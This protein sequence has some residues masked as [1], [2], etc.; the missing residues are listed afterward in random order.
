MGG[1]C[2]ARQ[3]I[4]LILARPLLQNIGRRAMVEPTIDLAPTPDAAA[5]H[6]ADRRLAERKAEA[7]VA[8]FAH[9]LVARKM[10]ARVQGQVRPFFQQQRLK[11]RLGAQGGGDGSSRP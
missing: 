4:D 7:P 11:A 8:I 6:I 10:P 3:R 1:K 9:D 5:F 2:L